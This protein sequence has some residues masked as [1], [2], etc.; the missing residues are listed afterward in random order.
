MS[1]AVLAYAISCILGAAFVRGYSGFGFSL[2]AISAISLVLPT[3]TVVP[4][5]TPETCATGCICFCWNEEDFVLCS[6]TF[7]LTGPLRCV[8]KSPE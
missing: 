8:A 3:A 7:E 5:M 4:A 1:W 2:L 6:L